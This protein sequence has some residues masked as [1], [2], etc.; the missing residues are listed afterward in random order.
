MVVN[1]LPHCPASYFAEYSARVTLWCFFTW[2]SMRLRLCISAKLQI[3]QRYTLR[4]MICNGD[5]ICIKSFISNLIPSMQL[6]RKS[7]SAPNWFVQAYLHFG[8]LLSGIDQPRALTQVPVHS[9]LCPKC[10][11]AQFATVAAPIEPEIYLLIL[12]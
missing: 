2:L 6:N 1:W 10:I 11:L 7:K 5:F 9:A 3:L 4:T 12:N 8:L